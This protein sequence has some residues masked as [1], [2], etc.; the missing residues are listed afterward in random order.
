MRVYKCDRCKK[1]IDEDDVCIIKVFGD[2]GDFC[3]T[4]ADEW[5]TIMLTIKDAF[6][7]QQ[8]IRIGDGV[9]NCDMNLFDPEKEE[10]NGGQ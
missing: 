2:D 1:E 8:T 4:C 10:N 9:D 6:L 7:K 3:E 5:D